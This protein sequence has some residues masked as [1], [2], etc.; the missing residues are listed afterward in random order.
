MK[1]SIVTAAFNAGSTI[2]D[3]LSSIMRQKNVEVE[4]IV[5]DGGSTDDTLRIVSSFG[6][7]IAKVVSEPDRGPYDA[8]RKGLDCAT[9]DVVAFLNAD[10]Y[11]SDSSVLSDVSRSF[12]AGATVVAGTVELFVPSGRVVRIIKAARYRPYKMRWGVVPPHPGTFALTALARRAGGFDPQFK[13]AGDFDLFFRMSR[14][15]D[16]RLATIDRTLTMMRLGGMSTTGKLIYM[17]MAPE[18]KLALRKNGVESGNWR[19]DLRALWKLPE[20]LTG[21][22]TVQRENWPSKVAPGSPA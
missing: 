2:G 11:Y 17:R 20:L 14:Q 4:A 12:E 6:N 19:V 15:A 8:M 7:H 9:G 16:F 21:R 1:F 3:T 10:D 5:I 18:L 13:Y 22:R